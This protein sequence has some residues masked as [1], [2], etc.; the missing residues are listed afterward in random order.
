M[1]SC[2]NS[3]RLS[4]QS[5]PRVLHVRAP[6]FLEQLS[7]CFFLSYELIRRETAARFHF[8]PKPL[9]YVAPDPLA[10]VMCLGQGKSHAIQCIS[11]DPSWLQPPLQLP[12]LATVRVGLMPQRLYVTGQLCSSHPAYFLISQRPIVCKITPFSVDSTQRG[13]VSLK[14]M[15]VKKEKHMS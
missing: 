14:P 13:H 1:F 8:S 2:L 5:R 11:S 4:F 12:P 10:N 9:P 7:H 3:K 6:T 15:P